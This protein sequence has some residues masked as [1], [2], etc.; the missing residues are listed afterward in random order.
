MLL[1]VS[2]D[3]DQLPSAGPPP[4][5][6]LTP[7]VGTSTVESVYSSMFIAQSLPAVSAAADIE[8]S[9]TVVPTS[10]INGTTFTSL[11]VPVANILST[12]VAPTSTSEGANVAAALPTQ[13]PVS[14]PLAPTAGQGQ[15]QSSAGGPTSSMR[16]GAVPTAMPYV[17]GAAGVVA[18]AIGAVALL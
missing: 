15:G 4:V 3:Q 1:T 16:A 2:A 6:T 5:V 17:Q 18:A 10:T 14:A 13:T 9:T 12:S 7:F 8:L 11:V